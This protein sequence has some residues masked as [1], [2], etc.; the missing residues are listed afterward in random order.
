MRSRPPS[1]F[2]LSELCYRVLLFCTFPPHF[3]RQFG[4]EMM[5]MFRDRCRREYGLAGP[6]GLCRLWFRTLT[7]L[8]RQGTAERLR[9]LKEKR[10]RSARPKV[11]RAA[12]L[13]SW[14]YD[15]RSALRSLM[16][17]R[18]FTLTAATSLA[19]GIG[20]SAA[21]LS[22]VEAVH[23]R[24]LPFP[25]PGRLTT[26]WRDDRPHGVRGW[27]SYPDY[28]DLIE[29]NR[30]FSK[31]A[32]FG[33]GVLTLMSERGPVRV[34]AM[35]TSQLFQVLAVELQQG[36]PFTPQEL[37]R[38]DRVAI[39][40]DR[41]WKQH[42]GGDPSLVG[43]SIRLN[44][45]S[46]TVVGIAPSG[47]DFP[48]QS[49]LW[50][51]LSPSQGY[52]RGFYWLRVVARLKENVSLASA[53]RDV[54]QII[55]RLEQEYPGRYK[56]NGADLTPLH[57]YL[58]EDMGSALW[59]LLCGA[60][61]VL[62]VA[63]GNVA[64]LLLARN[65]RRRH[66]LAVRSALGAGRL[67]MAR[68]MILESLFL[69]GLGALGGAVLAVAGIRLLALTAPADSPLGQEGVSISLL[70][71]ALALGLI[72]SLLF[73]LMPSL[74][75]TLICPGK[76]LSSNRT[77]W[78]GRDRTRVRSALLICEVALAVVLL[79]GTGLLVKSM[80][81]LLSVD[82]G[83][84]AENILT[85]EMHLPRHRYREEERI[86]QFVEGSRQ[87]VSAIPGVQAAGHVE[88]LPFSNRMWGTRL[89]AEGQPVQ[90]RPER[91]I[92]NY[93][94]AT[95]GYFEAL[96]VPLLRGRMFDVRDT[97]SSQPVVLINSTL[98]EQL[99]PGKDP[100][101]AR[102]TPGEP[103]V[104]NWLRVV[105]VVGD[106]RNRGLPK[107]PRGEVYQVIDQLP[108]RE[109]TLV[110]R[111]PAGQDVA[112]ALR[113][114]LQKLEPE[115]PVEI[116]PL[117]GLVSQSV[118][119]RR[120]TLILLGLFS[121]LATGLALVGIYGVVAYNVTQRTAE[122]GLRMALG[123]D[124]STILRMILGQGGR[125]AL[126]GLAAGL[127]AAFACSR[128]LADLLFQVEPWDGATLLSVSLICLGSALLASAIPALRASRIDPA[129][130]LRSE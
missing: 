85:V 30:S 5:E 39:V 28:V 7:D 53:Q 112:P 89:A 44:G 114:V 45:E 42:L 2:P 22:L 90:P 74:S 111:A 40:G 93:N 66:D 20:A 69:G 54:E 47:F 121:S 116:R 95:A 103:E 15:C 32:A 109:V 110:V 96:R 73:G 4:Q 6:G 64:N 68:Q 35:L 80:W 24:P 29:R 106:V 118:S 17:S 31:V 46:V 124:R 10:A 50:V 25:E 71:F 92:V 16:R 11:P 88:Y 91:I 38:G 21:I 51:P 105:G 12:S 81:R 87:A 62:L 3:R 19:L 43:S 26:I 27:F 65:A 86:I 130:S 122:M 63:C 55:A 41:L 117:T 115:L 37:D 84:Q 52:G 23:F 14:L 107:A 72:T 76:G 101:G 70:G 60:G 97:A 125:L 33:G 123:A 113:S 75:A 94:A 128:L 57:D 108:S 8:I 61:L 79:T 98:A 119:G 83:F 77:S 48:N 126:A 129:L 78:S 34:N 58:A 49:Q 120:F 67:R 36:R 13:G 99:W 56:D 59:I 100:V 102:I 18:L 82:K 1:G 104:G 127:A 9:P